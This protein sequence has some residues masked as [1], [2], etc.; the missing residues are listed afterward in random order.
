M[1]KKVRMSLVLI[2]IVALLRGAAESGKKNVIGKRAASYIL[3]GDIGRRFMTAQGH[4]LYFQGAARKE[5][6]LLSL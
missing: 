3:L 5:N 1:E 4:T 6:C 2:V